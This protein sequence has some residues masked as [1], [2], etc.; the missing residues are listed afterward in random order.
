MVEQLR[1]HGGLLIGLQLG[2]SIA[3]MGLNAFKRMSMI[4]TLL[5]VLAVALPASTRLMPLW[6]TPLFLGIPIMATTLA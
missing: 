6:S 1:E 4:S 3:T 5:I 2:P